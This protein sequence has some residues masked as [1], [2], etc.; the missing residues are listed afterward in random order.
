VHWEKGKPPFGK[1]T[2]QEKKPVREGEK[3]GR[4]EWR[5]GEVVEKKK[6][7]KKRG[8]AVVADKKRSRAWMLQGKEK[9]A[10]TERGTGEK[11]LAFEMQGKGTLHAKR[12]KD[13]GEQGEGNT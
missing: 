3:R 1:K 12:K 13:A 9:R 8:G 7:K 2:Y 5:R 10:A 4:R 6:I 11:G